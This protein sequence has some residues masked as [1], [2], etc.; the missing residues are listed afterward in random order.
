MKLHERGASKS[1]HWRRCPNR[2]DLPRT[3]ACVGEAWMLRGCDLLRRQ[4]TEVTQE[5]LRGSRW[6]R[7][8]RVPRRRQRR[9]ALL[10][11]RKLG[12]GRLPLRWRRKRWGL[13]RLGLD[14]R[15]AVVSSVRAVNLRHAGGDLA[16]PL[17]REAAGQVEEAHR[18]MGRRLAI[19]LTLSSTCSVQRLRGR[20]PLFRAGRWSCRQVPE[21]SARKC[22][23]RHWRTG[24]A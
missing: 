13:W 12:L 4:P 16:L 1:P 3:P 23:R 8:P 10:W 15:A 21:G 11:M 2:A 18:L 6:E 5:P 9:W 19:L 7:P 24:A 14:A 22:F 17:H 20:A